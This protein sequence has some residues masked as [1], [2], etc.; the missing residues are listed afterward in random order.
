MKKYFLLLSVLMLFAAIS[1]H[2]QNTCASVFNAQTIQTSDPS[3][4]NSD[5]QLEQFTSNYIASL[6]TGSV[7]GRVINANST[8]IIPVVVHVLHIGEAIGVGNNISDAQVQ[9][10]IAVLNEDFRRLNANRVNTPAAF[11]GVAADPNFEFRLACIDPNGN[12]TTGIH[13]V[14]TGVNSFN[15]VT[16]AN[17]S[18]NEQASGIKFTAQGGTNA[19]PTGRYL[20]I[21]VCNIAPVGNLQLLGY[22]QFPFD[23]T[24]SP[25]TD[26]VVILNTA[27]GRVGPNLRPNF[28]QGRT[29]THEIGHWLNLFHIWGDDNTA[30]T[31]TDQCDDTPNQGGAN[32]SNCPGFPHVSCTNGPNG[33]M[34]MNYMDYTID[35][36]KNIYTQGQRNRMRAVFAAGGPREAFI[37]NY[38][39]LNTPTSAPVCT[40]TT[41][42]ANNPMC[43]PVT[44]TITGPATI[45]GNG[46]SATVTRTGNGVA[47]VTATAG[48]FTDSKTVTVGIPL[49]SNIAI[50]SSKTSTTVG[51][52]VGFVAG[53]PPMNRCEIQ[54]AGWQSSLSANIVLGDYECGVSPDN[55]TTKNIFF[56][57]TGTAYVQARIQNA[58]GWS[59][60]SAAVPIQ[61]GSGFSYMVT[62]N[63]ATSMATITQKGN[64]NADITEVK[65]FDNI[66]NLRKKS[67]YGTGT[68]QAQINIS[69][70]KTGVYF[71][72]ISSGQ[73]KERQQLII[74][75]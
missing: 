44:W 15:V 75:N 20:N 33:D 40:S 43:L 39:A 30:C 25:N 68:K 28:N 13:R 60:W 7:A 67:K 51:N 19:W 50:W 61:V 9:S 23:Y 57:T 2:S 47:T 38:F 36:C 53:Y 52:P 58:C 18:I 37:N 42:T 72:E 32:Q 6:N 66:G 26:G 4:Y 48:G 71:I 73:N 55:G 29:T 14:Q 62:P 34:F 69:D 24:V 17:G 27:F 49:A 59:N 41:V 46:N 22:A 31:G 74:Q 64:S 16:N 70:L 3:R 56:Q 11:A 54:S 21:W 12:A 65:V 10:Q 5:L 8:I 45:A 1:S 35:A 63:P